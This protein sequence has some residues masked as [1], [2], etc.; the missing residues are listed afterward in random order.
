MKFPRLCRS[1]SA[2]SNAL[3]ARKI[4]GQFQAFLHCS[5][6]KVPS[7]QRTCWRPRV[8]PLHNCHGQE[9][10]DSSNW[11]QP[12][13]FQHVQKWLWYDSHLQFCSI[14][15]VLP[16]KKRLCI[17][18]RIASLRSEGLN[19]SL[20]TYFFSSYAVPAHLFSTHLLHQ[21]KHGLHISMEDHE[22]YCL[23]GTWRVARLLSTVCTSMPYQ[24]QVWSNL[25]SSSLSSITKKIL[26]R[27]HLQMLYQLR[28]RMAHFQRKVL[29]TQKIHLEAMEVWIILY[30]FVN[31]HDQ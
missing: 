16:C 30:T 15:Y 23:K 24:K 18:N 6:G 20:T 29:L 21:L 14:S 26:M 8:S 13:I 11:F 17:P 31:G 1:V 9:C 10:W 4:R 2:A 27:W 3:W 12:S 19:M 25:K 22:A 7:A 28:P 5:F